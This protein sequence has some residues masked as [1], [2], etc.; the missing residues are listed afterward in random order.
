VI[1]DGT[2]ELWDRAH[3]RQERRGRSLLLFLLTADA[4]VG[5]SRARLQVSSGFV[6]T[7]AVGMTSSL[8]P[9]LSARNTPAST[10]ALEA[11]ELLEGSFVTFADWP[12]NPICNEEHGRE[13]QQERHLYLDR[14]LTEHPERRRGGVRAEHD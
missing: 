6:S 2:P 10:S 5:I 13:P 8:A 9:S 12:P 7:F 11:Y 3:D 4:G 14:K 1:Q